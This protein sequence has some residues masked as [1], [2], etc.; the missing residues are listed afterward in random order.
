M[1]NM[2]LRS[3]LSLTEQAPQ[4]PPMAGPVDAPVA[5]PSDA[6]ANQPEEPTP[7]PEPTDSPNP[8]SAGEY[9]WTKDFRAFEDTKNQAES[10]AKKKLLDKMNKLILGKTIVANA[11]RGYGQPKTDYTIK[12]VK[13]VSVE[14]WYKDYVAIVTDENDKKY[15]LTPGVNLKIEAGQEPEAGA[16]DP[17]ASPEQQAPEEPKGGEEAPNNG[18]PPAAPAEPNADAAPQPGADIPGPG[19]PQEPPPSAMPA[20]APQTQQPQAP[21]APEEQPPLKK[22]KRLPVAEW[23]QTDMSKV[24]NDYMFEGMKD[25]MGNVDYMNYFVNAELVTETNN[26]TKIKFTLQIPVNH[27][28][29]KIDTRDIRLAAVDILRESKYGKYAKGS[30]DVTKVGRLYY[31]EYVKEIGWKL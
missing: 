16:E 13:K 27:M 22:K 18:V 30:V 23:V 21:A 15:F 20:A 25:A 10:E 28:I 31:V 29:D 8:E 26:A 9:D 6:A 19:L 2:K 5:P 12:S 24:L 14:F 11:S 1:N 7:T 3:L 4:A 17:N